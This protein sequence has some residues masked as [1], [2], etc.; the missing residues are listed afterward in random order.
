LPFESTWDAKNKWDWSNL[1]A[2]DQLPF[3]YDP[4]VSG[5][6]RLRV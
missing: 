1:L 4:E 3:A 5:V 6:S 2:A